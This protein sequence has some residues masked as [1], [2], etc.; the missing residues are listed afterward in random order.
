MSRVFIIG[1]T[2]QAKLCKIILEE[3]GHSVPIVYDRSPSVEPPFECEIFHD[4]ALIEE[5]AKS[6][7]HFL[8]CIGGDQGA[9]RSKY[10]ERLLRAG[11]RPMP[12]IHYQARIGRTVVAGDGLQAMIGATVSEF[13]TIGDW[14][15]LNTNCTVDHECRIGRGVHIMGGA[16]VAGLVEIGDYATV[17]TNATILPRIKIGEGSFVGAGAVVT[18]DVPS[19]SVAVGVPARIKLGTPASVDPSEGEYVE[20]RAGRYG[21][22]GTNLP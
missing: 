11:L 19:Y 5:K 22:S 15:I 9:D 6:C 1:G 21:R 12:A 16:A 8:V 18:K 13:A 7:S 3:A 2:G 14:C 4:S 10:S 20:K 17:G